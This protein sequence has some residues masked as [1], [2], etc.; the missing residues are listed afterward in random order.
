MAVIAG[1]DA[2]RWLKRVGWPPILIDR[3]VAYCATAL[4]GASRCEP[5]SF[6]ASVRNFDQPSRRLNP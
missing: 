5:L 4:G 6:R 1:L 2:G 3:H